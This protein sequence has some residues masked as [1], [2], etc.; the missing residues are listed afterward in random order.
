MHSGRMIAYSGSHYDILKYMIMN[1]FI[2]LIHASSMRTALMNVNRTIRRFA[3][4]F[5][6]AYSYSHLL[7]VRRQCRLAA[8]IKTWTIDIVQLFEVMSYWWRTKSNLNL[9]VLLS[10]LVFAKLST[11]EWFCKDPLLFFSHSVFW[12]EYGLKYRSESELGTEFW[13]C[14]DT[15]L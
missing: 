9:V 15:L 1:T 14:K 11:T 13:S 10:I 12:F 2:Q 5:Q 7:L 3:L 8:K 4:L 6:W